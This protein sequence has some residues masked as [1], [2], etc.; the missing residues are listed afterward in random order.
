M[1]N[2]EILYG[3]TFPLVRCQLNQGEFVKAESDAMV[4]MQPTIDVGST[5]EGGLL[6]GI[7]RMLAGEK[8]FFQ[9][10]TAKSGPGEVLFSSAK[11]GSII[12]FH[13]DGT[14][15]M[16]IQKD[17]FLASEASINIGTKMQNISKGLFSKQGFFILKATGQ[18]LVFLSC[19]GAAHTIQV[20]PGE[21]YIVDNGHL[22][23]WPSSMPYTL[24]KASKGI[25]KSITSG[26]GF[27]CRFTGPGF[28]VIQTRN[29]TSFSG[30][31]SSLL[32][33]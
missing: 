4:A 14:Y 28:I 29:P 33:G 15:E 8:F 25:F 9:T 6:G 31:L 18:G 27:V 13:M 20:P 30:W 11:P 10:L 22:V 7:G 1:L 5:L 19:L 2:Y 3:N 17:G 24:E 21:Q 32:P 23:A 12:D 16:S 26:E